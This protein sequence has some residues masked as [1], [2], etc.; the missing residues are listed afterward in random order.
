[1]DTRALLG[2][3][4]GTSSTKACLL[5]PSGSVLGIGASEYA[6][7]SPQPGWAEQDPET[8][9]DAAVT[10]IGAAL[11][12]AGVAPDAVIGISLSGQMHGT[13]CMDCAGK[14]VRPAIIWADQRSGRQ[15]RAVV[16]Q[17]GLRRLATWTGNPLAT[18]FTLASWL[19]LKEHERRTVETTRWVL[20]PKDYVRYRLTGRVTSEPSDAS[21]T[22][23]F[24]PCDRAWSRTL[25]D[26]L[27]LDPSVLPEVHPTTSVSGGLLPEIAERMGLPTGI[28]VVQGASDQAAQAVGNGV[29]GPGVVSS[30]IGTGGQLLAPVQRCAVDPH[31]RLHCFCHVSPGLWHLETAMLSAGLS[32]RWLRDSLLMGMT[33]DAMA[34]AAETVAPGA[35]GLIFLP[36][37]VGERTPYM[38]P[39]AR[40]G[41]VGLTRRHG[42]EHLIRAVMEG[43]VFG[44]RQG[45]DL[46]ARLG[47]ALDF[48]VASGGGTRHRLWLQ[49]QADIFGRP[50]RSTRSEEAAALGAAMLAGVGVGVYADVGDAVARC[51]TWRDRVVY[52]MEQFAE[53]YA[54]R[55]GNY[56]DL[57]PAL[58]PT[59]HGLGAASR[60]W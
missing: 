10:A 47:V 7:S 27:D 53:I 11:S 4:I 2:I 49:L 28:P 51:V 38:D 3:D 29:V 18:G 39:L 8:W 23:L 12:R 56:C 42:P 36:Y 35:E 19:W 40:G 60:E 48:M 45:L 59:L 30:T 31:L 41:F 37:L 55:Y 25:L 43:V 20:L 24:S 17:L 6:I 13:V 5:S 50:V 52:P 34:D 9:L 21:S 46:M 44:M 57:Y 58:Q 32:L 54:R 16:S 26:E 33:Y 15:V 1:V 22:S 14:P